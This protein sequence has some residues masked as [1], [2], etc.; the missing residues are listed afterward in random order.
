MT[1]PKTA[2]FWGSLD[3][4]ADPMDVARIIDQVP[5]G[6]IVYNKNIP[7]YGHMDFVWGENAHVDVYADIVDLLK[8]Y[9]QK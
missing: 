4:L 2:M 8:K 7:I 6:T 9:A 1:G 3:D 5:N